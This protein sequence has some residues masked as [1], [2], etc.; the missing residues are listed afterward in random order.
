MNETSR[1]AAYWVAENFFWVFVAILFLNML[2]RRGQK[3][4]EKKRFATLYL[5]LGAFAFYVAGLII[6]ELGLTD[7]L[8]IPSGLLILGVLYYYRDQ[9]FPFRLHCRETGERLSW[10]EI[11]YDDSNL[12]AKAKERHSREDSPTEGEDGSDPD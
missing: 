11:I 12:S 2:Q 3:R 4:A 8:L 9:T 5:G 6:L 1:T 7:L 10:E